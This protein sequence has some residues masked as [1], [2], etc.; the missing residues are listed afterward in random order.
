MWENLN[1]V[2]LARPERDGSLLIIPEERREREAAETE[3]VELER[4]VGLVN[5]ATAN[6]RRTWHTSMLACLQGLV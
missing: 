5:R 6:C 1:I 3:R 2:P 4:L